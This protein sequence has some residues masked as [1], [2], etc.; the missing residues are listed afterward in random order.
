[1]TYRSCFIIS[2]IESDQKVNISEEHI[3][4]N[5]HVEQKIRNGCKLQ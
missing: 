4:T 2:H 3:K 1:M 5:N